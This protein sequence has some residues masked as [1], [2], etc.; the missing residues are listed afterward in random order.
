[1][2][3]RFLGKDITYDTLKAMSPQERE[4]LCSELRDKILK[5]VS[6][7]GGHLARNLGAVELTVA[8]LSVFDY[9]RDK[10]IFDVGHQAYSYKLLTGRYDRFDT[11]R[12]KDGISGFPRISESPYD[13]LDT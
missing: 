2:D 6:A 13:A 12:Q 5:T 4:V 9:K 3:Y 10:I 1:M 11:L 7:N 8:L